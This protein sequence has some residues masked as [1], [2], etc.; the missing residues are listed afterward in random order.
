MC[1]VSYDNGGIH[2]NSGVQNHWFYV[3]SIGDQDVND[4]GDNYNV[5]GIG[6]DKAIQIAFYSM[7]NIL[8][9]SSNYSDARQSA[10]IASMILF[11]ECSNEHIQTI[12]SWYACR[13]W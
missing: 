9:S 5:Q 6:P 4:I 13:C 7:K 3:L 2:V 12:N 11:G 8:F 10:I 1:D